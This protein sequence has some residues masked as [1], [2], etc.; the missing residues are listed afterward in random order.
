MIQ[1]LDYYMAFTQDQDW[2]KGATPIVY[3]CI[4][5]TALNMGVSERQI[6]RLE[7]ALYSNLEPYPGRIVEITNDTVNGVR[8]Q[9]VYC[10]PLV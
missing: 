3:Q 1:L 9:V 8:L 7:A 2:K 5:K 10:M 4:A 6:Q